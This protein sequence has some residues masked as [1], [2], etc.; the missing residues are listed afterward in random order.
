AMLAYVL[1]CGPPEMRDLE[2]AHRWYQRSAAAGC[3]EG[4]LGYALSLA[5]RTQDEAGRQEVAE[6]L[7]RA[8]E[9]ELPTALY[10]L[11]VLTEQEVGVTRDPAVAAELYHH[12]AER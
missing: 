11:A 7:R 5:P 9:A 4:C 10:L 3:P 1:T 6:H 8:A 2:G 12:A